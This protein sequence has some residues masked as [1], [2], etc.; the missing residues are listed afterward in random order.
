MIAVIAT[1]DPPVLLLQT[2]PLGP[3]ERTVAVPAFLARKNV[4]VALAGHLRSA[5][6]VGART[7]VELDTGVP[8]GATFPSRWKEVLESSNSTVEPVATWNVRTP[9][10]PTMSLLMTTTAGSPLWTLW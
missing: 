1:H 3:M 2:I 6:P 4:Q 9:C 10:M 7:D 5:A 8:Q